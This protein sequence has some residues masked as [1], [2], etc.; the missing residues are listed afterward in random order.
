MI[1]KLKFTDK[2][3]AVT[4]LQNKGVIDEEGNY[5][6]GTHAVVYIGIIVDQ[7]GTYDEEGN[8]LTPTTFIEGFHVD[9][10]TDN[11]IDFGMN[12]VKVNNPIH[13]FAQ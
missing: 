6:N 1:H 5:I 13:S 12:E 2:A 9:I 11:T 7:Q 8:E 3:Q 4:T 10:M